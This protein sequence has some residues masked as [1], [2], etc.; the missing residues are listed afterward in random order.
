[1]ERRYAL[2][3]IRGVANYQFGRGVGET[4]FP[5]NV[6]IE[7]S[8]ATG[9][10]RFVYLR[11][12]LLATLR[13]RNGTFALTLSGAKRLLK[14]LPPPRFRVVVINEVAN[15]IA[16][17]RTVFAKHVIKADPEIRP[18]EEVVVL[19]SGGKML[20]VGK[21]LLTGR[22]MLVFKRG[23]AVKV[24]R[25]LEEEAVVEEAQPQGS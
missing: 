16:E 8:R 13:A 14:A 9:K 11:G 24:R 15:F 6:S 4:L 10:I 23:V 19:N 5:D 1:M 3:K 17:G 25:G 12:K 2:Q 20:A 7:Y 22:E 21:A 18:H